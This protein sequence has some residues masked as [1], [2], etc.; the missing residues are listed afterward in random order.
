MIGKNLEENIENY[1]K[2]KIRLKNARQM[3][4]KPELLLKIRKILY[5]M[6]DSLVEQVIQEKREIEIKF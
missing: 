1:Q 3:N 2:L 4:M 5:N 6:Q